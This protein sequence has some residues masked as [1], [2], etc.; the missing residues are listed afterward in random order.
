LGS[1]PVPVDRRKGRW[2][3]SGARARDLLPND[4]R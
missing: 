4:A 2:L 3:G 1:W